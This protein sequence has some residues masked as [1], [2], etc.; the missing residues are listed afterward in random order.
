MK[1]IL[2]RILQLV[3]CI[4]ISAT[5]L[6]SNAMAL[7]IQEGAEAARAEGMPAELIGADGVINKFTNIALYAVGLIAVFML[8]WGGL[9]YILSGGDSKKITDAKN[10]ILYAILGLIIAFFAYAIVNFV[11]NS[12]SDMTSPK[13]E[14]ES[15]EESDKKQEQDSTSLLPGSIA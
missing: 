3:T 4:S 12:I 15:S 9:R 14:D 5:M 10:T 13:R 2:K 1:S 8:I 6:T 7:T 11:L